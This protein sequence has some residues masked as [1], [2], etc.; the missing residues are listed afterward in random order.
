MGMYDFLVRTSFFA[1]TQFGFTPGRNCED[2][3]LKVTGELW[4]GM[5]SNGVPENVA[6][7]LDLTKT[8][9]LVDHGLLV[10][11]LEMAGFRG[12]AIE[13]LNSYICGRTQRVRMSS[14]CLSDPEV[15]GSGVPQGSVL[16]PLLFLIY[17]NSLLTMSLTGSITAY[18]D[19][20]TLVYAGKKP[21]DVVQDLRVDLKGISMW[22]AFHK[23]VMSSKTVAMAFG[24]SDY[25]AYR[26][27]VCHASGC[28]EEPGSRTPNCSVK[29]VDIC[30]VK[31]C[32]YLGVVLDRELNWVDHAKQ[33]RSNIRSLNRQL[34]RLR[35]SCSPELLR[36]FYIAIGES[37]LRYGLLCWG[38]AAEMA[39]KPLYISQ[40]GCIRTMSFARRCHPSK[41]LFIGWNLLPLRCLYVYRV[42]EFYFKNS[43]DHVY[44]TRE[45]N[46]R[47]S[48][49]LIL[50]RPRS[51]AFRRSF[52]YLAP[53]IVNNLR[54]L[55]NRI[56]P[57]T[58]K[59]LL[60]STGLDNIQR[61][62]T[63]R[64]V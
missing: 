40:K 58:V 27:L 38:G 26:D 55:V 19:D 5:N 1:E 21:L 59:E 15:C 11:K 13:W 48:E 20:V 24:K 34:Y 51:E 64:Y 36:S 57:N 56:Y 62:L 63:S 47:R 42:S 32:K 9:D 22:L 49:A 52:A 29:C 53:L 6:L 31:S 3:L 44:F 35:S 45:S 39:L 43:G 30:F 37:R 10:G 25:A 17:I 16:G 41:N 61:I 12:V 4:S 7:F 28:L 23:M 8:F 50:P 60:M 54:E 18:A 33:L 14:G 46:A 2:A